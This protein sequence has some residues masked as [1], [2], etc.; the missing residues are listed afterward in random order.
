MGL[1][2]CYIGIL[3]K[4]K[5]SVDHGAHTYAYDNFFCLFDG[6]SVQKLFIDTCDGSKQMYLSIEC[7]NMAQ[8]N[9]EVK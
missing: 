4:T 1:D 2:V 9:A 7:D 5:V 3:K 6:L 8:S